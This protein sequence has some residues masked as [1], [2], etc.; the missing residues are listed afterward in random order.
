VRRQILL[1]ILLLILAAIKVAHADP[2]IEAGTSIGNASNA[3]AMAQRSLGAV[4]TSFIGSLSLY[5][6]VGRGPV[7]FDLGMQNRFTTLPGASGSAMMF[8]PN[9][10]AR[11]EF[12]RVYIGGGYAPKVL[13]DFKP[14]QGSSA[15][16]G[17]AGAIWR[18]VPELQICATIAMEYGMP[19]SGG[20]SP[21]PSTEY[22]LRFRFPLNPKE[23]GSAR[24]VD[25]DGYRYPFGIM[26]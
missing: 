18:V 12:W 23:A 25:W 16:F 20:K 6:P 22:G 2:Y 7:H 15:Y 13:V 24:G 11:I 14:Y 1:P 26:R 9:V 17:E 4:G 21:S 5:F 8:T 10:A 3:D 19:A